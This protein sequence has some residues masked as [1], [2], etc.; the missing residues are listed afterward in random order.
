ML[1]LLFFFKEANHF[2]AESRNSQCLCCTSCNYIWTNYVV[3][4]DMSVSVTDLKG[5]Y[6]FIFTSPLRQKAHRQ[7]FRL[8]LLR[9]RPHHLFCVGTNTQPVSNCGRTLPLEPFVHKWPSVFH[10]W[11]CIDLAINTKVE[12]EQRQDFVWKFNMLRLDLRTS[13]IENDC[14][15]LPLPRGGR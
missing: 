13:N 4:P 1:H 2:P 7:K 3:P 8:L 9:K 5:K 12:W 15:S 10:Q 6:E 14:R 11:E